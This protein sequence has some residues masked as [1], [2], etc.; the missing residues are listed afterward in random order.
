MDIVVRHESISRQHA[1][2]V[3][4]EKETF[5]IDLGSASGSFVD[6]ERVPR[7]QTRKLRDGA[8]ITLGDCR[9]SYTLV[10]TK[11]AAGVAGGGQKRKR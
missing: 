1:A 2:I 10:L 4:A 3:H 6:G 9:A 5:L 8:V 11:P 7:D